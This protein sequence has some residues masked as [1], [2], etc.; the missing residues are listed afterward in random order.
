MPVW[1]LPREAAPEALVP[2]M[3]LPMRPSVVV[4]PR[5]RMPP[6]LLPAMTLPAAADVPPTVALGVL[7]TTTPQKVL[8]ILALAAALRP[9]V[10]PAM[11]TVPAPVTWMPCCRLPEMRF[12]SAASLEPSA[13]VPMRVLLADVSTTTPP[14]SEPLAA[15]PMAADPAALVPM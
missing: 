3:L 6:W 4:A 1:A 9:M 13:L 11:V 15:L 10:L 7:V 8:P 5:K 2:T 14:W 12:P